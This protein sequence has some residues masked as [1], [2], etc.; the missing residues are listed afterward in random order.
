MHYKWSLSLCSVLSLSEHVASIWE[1][2]PAA[3][4]PLAMTLTANS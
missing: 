4:L 3:V 2:G 1:P